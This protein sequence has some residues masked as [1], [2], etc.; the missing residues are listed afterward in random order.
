M[1]Y[2]IGQRKGLHLGGQEEPFY[3]AGHDLK[4]QII[5]VAPSSDKSYL[6][7]DEAIINDVNWLIDEKLENKK[8][9]VKFRYK[10]ESV[11]C[12]IEWINEK[13]FRVIY[14]QGFEAVTPG[15]QAVFYNGN[16]CIGGGSISKIYSNGNIKTF[17]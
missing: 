16:Y 2:T 13:T 11:D 10:S 3:V 1:Y 8:L 14:P 4:K 5:Y 6:M 15:Q 9:E 17:V 12:S 7:S